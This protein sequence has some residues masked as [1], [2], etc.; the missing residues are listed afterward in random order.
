[1]KLTQEI[2]E[3]IDQSVLCWLATVSKNG[4]PNVSPKECFTHYG[5]ESII[6][7][8]IASPNTVRNIGENRNVCLSILDILVQK[9]FQIHGK[10]EIIKKG[11]AQ[12]EEMFGILNKMTKGKFP[13]KTITKINIEKVK[14]IIAPS[15]L[16]YPETT[17]EQQIENSKIT[18]GF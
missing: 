10:A 17:E 11:G 7:A 4:V 16:L 3:A 5:T 15:Y 9:G 6:V 8:N 2:K 1:M 13:F 12:F 14:P 18:Y